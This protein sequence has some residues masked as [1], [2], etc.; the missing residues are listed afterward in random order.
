MAYITCPCCNNPIYPF[1]T[2]KV[3]EVAKHFNIEPLISLPMLPNLATLVDNGNIE[4]EE[5]KEF[6][7]LAE[8]I[9]IA[10]TVKDLF[11]SKFPLIRKRGADNI[12]ELILKQEVPTYDDEYIKS[13][14]YKK[15]KKHMQILLDELIHITSKKIM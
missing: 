15:M 7:D 13:L 5:V 6:M 3:I 11:I 2:S 14:D 8:K 12:A 10:M 9:D 4:K 1:G